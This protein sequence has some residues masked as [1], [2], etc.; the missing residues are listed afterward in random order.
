MPVSS[1]TLSR[2]IEQGEDDGL[3]AVA[4]RRGDIDGP[5]ELP[6]CR[7]DEGGYYL[8]WSFGYLELIEGM[9]IHQALRGQP[10]PEDVMERR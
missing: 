7:L 8:A 1:D 3:I 6:D 4:F 5:Q 9:G 2:G 10:G